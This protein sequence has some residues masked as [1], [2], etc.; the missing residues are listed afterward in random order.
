MDAKPSKAQQLLQWAKQ[1]GGWFYLNEVPFAS[2][3]MSRA[4][5]S[6]A[7]IA[8]CRRGKMDFRIQGI[9]QYRAKESK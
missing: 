2:F 3:G 1:H 9:K 7:L 8:F 5:A 6:S 4:D